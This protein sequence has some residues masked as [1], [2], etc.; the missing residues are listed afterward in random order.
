MG[1]VKRPSC[2]LR[3]AYLRLLAEARELRAENASLR[4]DVDALIDGDTPP[5]LCEC[6]YCQQGRVE[7]AVRD[8][9]P[10][11]PMVAVGLGR[12]MKWGRS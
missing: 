4:A 9:T 5:S 10:L 2:I 6:R 7:D 11:P 12:A 1:V 3:T 8:M